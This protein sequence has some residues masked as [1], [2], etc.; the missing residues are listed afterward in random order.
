MLL[1]DA[2]HAGAGS[3]DKGQQHHDQHGEGVS[4]G[5]AMPIIIYKVY[6][7]VFVYLLP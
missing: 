1:L 2:E 7:S 5:C 6:G 4:C 3:P